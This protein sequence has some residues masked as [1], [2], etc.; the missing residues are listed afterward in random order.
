MRSFQGDATT[1]RRHTASLWAT[2]SDRAHAQLDAS[3]TTPSTLSGDAIC[4]SL[5][6]RAPAPAP[7]PPQART[8]TLARCPRLFHASRERSRQVTSL[9]TCGRHGDQHNSH[10]TP[11][12]MLSVPVS[13][14]YI[15][16]LNLASFPALK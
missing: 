2:R 9:K 4:F 6:P 13:I 14:I 1:R 11:K 12:H 10:A 5:V 15:N 7:A 16:S 3:P 8:H